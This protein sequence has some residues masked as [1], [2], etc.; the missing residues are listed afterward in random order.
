[1][2]QIR[3]IGGGLAGCEA[4]LFL[5]DHGFA[6]HLYDMK[7]GC[8]TAVHRSGDLAE[9]VCSNSFRSDSPANAVGVLKAEMRCLGSAIMDAAD[10]TRIPAGS[11]L[12]VD[13][14]AFSRYLTER[15]RQHEKIRFISEEVTEFNP[16][17]SDVITILS[18]GPL[19]TTGL[20][21]FLAQLTGREHLRFYDAIAPI[22]S[23]DSIDGT[24]TFLAS[25]YGK[26]GADYLNCP[27]DRET[28]LSFYRE[29][30][31]AET[32]ELRDFEK[33]CKL[34]EGCLPVESIARRG[35]DALR[36][37]PLKPVGLRHPETGSEFYAVVQLRAEDREKRY[38]NLVGFQTH[39]KQGEQKRVFRLIPGLENA[40][41]ERFGSMHRNTFIQSPDLLNNDFS[42]K[43]YP[44]VFVAGQI[45]GVE[46]YLE[47][48]ASGLIAAVS[49]VL[50]EKGV[51]EFVFPEKTM[52]GGLS[53]YITRPNMHFQPSNVIF[54]MVP[55]PEKRIRG[56]RRLRRE[57][58]ASRALSA[59]NEFIER[60]PIL[61]K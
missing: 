39:L 5:A 45:S 10:K 1:M 23:R 60:Y 51:R 36:F 19:A 13:R 6:V 14:S 28:Y 50:R 48:A 16:E 18:P 17:S 26:G 12:A 27:M 41:F 34:F 31:S 61:H 33:D 53:R 3:I 49:I 9:L 7:P 11:A 46:G 54:A 42:M 4:A 52:L 8:R 15:I 44:D 2:K 47:S 40:K 37:G 35:E 32:A 24:R 30:V 59:L 57:Y 55:G 25:R 56:G 38:Y 22:I 43:A 58:L 21:A 20:T 29:L